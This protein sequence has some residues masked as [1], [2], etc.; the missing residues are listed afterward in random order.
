MIHS[1]TLEASL[2]NAMKYPDVLQYLKDILLT[3]LKHLKTLQPYPIP[4]TRFDLH[5]PSPGFAPKHP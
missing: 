3:F 5:S 4:E 2:T 1:K